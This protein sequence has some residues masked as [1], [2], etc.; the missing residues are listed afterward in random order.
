MKSDANALTSAGIPDSFTKGG[1]GA[2]LAPNT[3]GDRDA[4]GT[5]VYGTSDG[6][7]LTVNYALDNSRTM[8]GLN[9]CVVY[10]TLV[11]T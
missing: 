2:S 3:S 10:G 8:A 5:V 11:G 4:A 1:K 7:A 9:V 6:R